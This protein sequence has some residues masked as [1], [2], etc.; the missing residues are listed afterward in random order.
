MQWDAFLPHVLPSVD[1]CTDGLALDHVVK[2]AREFCA[3]TRVWNFECDPILSVAGQPA[4]VCPLEPG[5]ELVRVHA[6]SVDGCDYGVGTGFRARRTDRAGSGERF[7]RMSYGTREFVLHPAP[8][9]D[10][11]SIV[12]DVAVQPS[13]DAGEWPD[14]LAEFV[15]DIAHGALASLLRMP[16]QPW[17]EKDASASENLLFQTRLMV[18]REDVNRGF[19]RSARANR[20]V[21]F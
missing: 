21:W 2:A 9:R 13:L 4:Y 5:Q 12:L 1:Q 8:K 10:G 20:S 18:V 11:Q 15:A 16:R 7:A 17:T 19:T 6:I 3:Q 14:D